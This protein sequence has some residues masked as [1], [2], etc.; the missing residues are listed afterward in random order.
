MKKF[1]SIISCVF[2]VL[3][4]IPLLLLQ[5]PFTFEYYT[6][7]TFDQ[8]GIIGVVIPIFY[9]VISFVFA[10]LSKRGDLKW[11]LLISSLFFL[12]VN[13]SLA[14]VAIFGFRNP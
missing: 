12:F 10:L 3:S 4:I 1:H 11:T 9:G 13:S 14:F 8:K 7:V 5:F 6:L 2:L